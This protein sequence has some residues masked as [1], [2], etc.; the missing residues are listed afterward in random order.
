LRNILLLRGGG[1][2]KSY[3]GVSV[4]IKFD[5]NAN[6]DARPAAADAVDRRN[7]APLTL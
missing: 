2:T 6:V 5:E 7:A 4:E 3:L 1:W